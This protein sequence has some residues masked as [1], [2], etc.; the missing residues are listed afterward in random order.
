MLSILTGA[1]SRE[2]RQ[3]RGFSRVLGCETEFSVLN[4]ATAIPFKEQSSKV[5]FFVMKRAGPVVKKL[6]VTDNQIAAVLKQAE[7][8]TS[9]KQ[10]LKNPLAVRAGYPLIQRCYP[11][12]GSRC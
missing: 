7:A 10:S 1:A 3:N 12:V 8:G 9:G 11:S 5:E 2:V 6:Q 4:M